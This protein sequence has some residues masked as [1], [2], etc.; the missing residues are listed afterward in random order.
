M[1]FDVK[2]FEKD[3]IQRS[4][5]I[6]VLVDFWAEWC[7]PCRT[8]SPTLEKLAVRHSGEWDLKK[9]NTEEFPDISSRYAIRSIP[10]VKLFSEG[11]AINEFVGAIPESS[12]EQWLRAALPDKFGHRLDQADLLIRQHRVEEARSLI[13]PI[14]KESPTHE[15]G[16]SLLAFAL[17][18]SDPHRALTLVNDIDASSEYAD[19]AETVRS[20]NHLLS[21]LDDASALP[22]LPVKAKYL[23]AIKSLSLGNYDDA[24]GRFIQIIREDRYYDEDGSRKACIGIFRYLGEE[25]SITAKYRREFGTALYV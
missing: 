11:S 3:V 10:N 6:P 22:D 2:D 15:R 20:W 13:E 8:L 7:G 1:N 4:S 17:L 16:R 25:S 12:I 21:R 19:A 23:A 14:L 5:A 24:L 9:L 18:T